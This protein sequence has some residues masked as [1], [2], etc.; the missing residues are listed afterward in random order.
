MK[1]LKIGDKF[2]LI[3][4]NGITYEKVI[5]D[6]DDDFIHW[7]LYTLDGKKFGSEMVQTRRNFI[8][9]NIKE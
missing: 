4:D 9:V 7:Q 3:G 2:N 6:L 5:T 8:K 1:E